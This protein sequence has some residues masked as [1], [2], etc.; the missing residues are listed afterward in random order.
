[1]IKKEEIVGELWH[2]SVWAFSRN[3]F[4]CTQSVADPYLV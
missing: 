3:G 4:S 1:M 2:Y